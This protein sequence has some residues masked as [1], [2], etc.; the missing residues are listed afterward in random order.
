MRD[1]SEYRIGQAIG[2]QARALARQPFEIAVLTEMH[3]RMQVEFAPK[4]EIECEIVMRRHQVGIV[5]AVLGVNIVA[6]RRLHA[7][8]NVAE[9]MQAEAEF[10]GDEMRVLLWVAPTGLN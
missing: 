3:D 1:V 2:R 10:S 8:D 6:A 4:P 9:A 7:D 5:I